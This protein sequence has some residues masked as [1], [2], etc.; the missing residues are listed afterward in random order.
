MK[1]AILSNGPGN[2]TTRRLKEEAKKRGHDVKVIKYK[3][4]YT[5]IESNNN[6]VRY[7]GE[8][9]EHFDAIIPRIAQSYTNEMELLNNKIQVLVD[10]KKKERTDIV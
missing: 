2:Y 1:I 3:D 10:E 4:A 7:K 9:L 5:A 6:R 8:S